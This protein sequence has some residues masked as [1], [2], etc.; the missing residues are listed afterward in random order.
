MKINEAVEILEELREQSSDEYTDMLGCLLHVHHYREYLGQ[1]SKL[2]PHLEEELI[3][4]ANF[5]QENYEKVEDEDGGS[6]WEWLNK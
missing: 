2:A 1:E 5:V 6:S 3:F 4:Q